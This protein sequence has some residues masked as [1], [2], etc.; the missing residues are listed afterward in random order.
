MVRKHFSQKQ[1]LS[2]LRSA[3][4]TNVKSAALESLVQPFY[5]S[6]IIAMGGHVGGDASP[7]RV[8][9]K[10]EVSDHIQYL[11]A[12]EFIGITEFRVD[13]FAFVHDDMGVQITAADFSKPLSY[14]DAFKGIE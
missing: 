12:Y 14:F 2:I 4:Q 11:M 6:L 9:E 7:D 1:K 3:K 8:A 5:Q 10:I 13:D